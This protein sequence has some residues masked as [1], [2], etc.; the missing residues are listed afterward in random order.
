VLFCDGRDDAARELEASM[1]TELDHLIA[2]VKASDKPVKETLE[3]YFKS[4]VWSSLKD[5]WATRMTDR[6]KRLL[7]KKLDVIK[8]IS[9]VKK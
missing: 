2:L 1:N 3:D 6:E 8:H 9:K 7:V 5:E 4:V